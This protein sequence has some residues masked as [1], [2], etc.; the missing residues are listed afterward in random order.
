MM[1][2]EGPDPFEGLEDEALI[3]I[4]LT[5][6]RA[7]LTSLAL[8]AMGRNIVARYPDHERTDATLS[9]MQ[10]IRMQLSEAA[11]AAVTPI[12]FADNVEDE[13]ANFLGPQ[14]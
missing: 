8:Q 13:L 3:T 7:A 5:P 4:T 10:A 14:A 6:R 12:G 1:D 11:I 2:D 9:H